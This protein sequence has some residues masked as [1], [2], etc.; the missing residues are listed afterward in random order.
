MWQI[1]VCIGL[2]IF[3]TGAT[4]YWNDTT[5]WDYHDPYHQF[6]VVAGNL[7]AIALCCVL[8]Y[9]VLVESDRKR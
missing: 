1:I 6:M 2:I 9:T 3:I 4:F 7:S 5:A 8:T